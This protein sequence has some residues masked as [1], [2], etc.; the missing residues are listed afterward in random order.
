[1]TS[2]LATFITLFSLGMILAAGGTL[3]KESPALTSMEE[4]NEAYT[5][6]DDASWAITSYH[7]SDKLG[8]KQHT[9]DNF[10]RNCIKTAPKGKADAFCGQPEL[11]RME[12][13]HLQPSAVR[14]YTE[15]GFKKIKA[16]EAVFSL[17]KEF[18]DQNRDQVIP[19]FTRVSPYHNSWDAPPDILHVANPEL[20][21]GGPPLLA[22]ISDAARDVLQEWTGQILAPSSVYG[23]RVYKNNSILSPHV[24]R[25]PLICSAIINVDQDVEEDWFLEVYDHD[26]VAHNVTMEPGD[27]VLYESHSTIHGRPFPMKGKHYANIFIHFEPIGD[28]ESMEG[29]PAKGSLPPYLIPGTE[30]EQWYRAAFPDGWNLLSDV[31]GLIHRGDMDTLRY[32]AQRDMGSLSKVVN[33]TDGFH[34]LHAAVEAG[35]VE[36]AKFFL[37]EVG[38]DVNT[39]LFVPFGVTSFDIAMRRFRGQKSHP[40][41]QLLK[42]KGGQPFRQLHGGQKPGTTASL[43]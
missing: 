14:N 21:G 27:M 42:E 10:M 13:N 25:I 22:A 3:R 40:M 33:T 6:F 36:I 2:S 24:D 26:G 41:L 5:S 19:E 32:V 38:T 28:L 37:E 1:M 39:P 8:N 15:T 9:Y 35:H 17:I 23:I 43:R 29:L 34:Y 4:G 7:L 12:R 18:W 31:T 20:E 11:E 30:W 16:P